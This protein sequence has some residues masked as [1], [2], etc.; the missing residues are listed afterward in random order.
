MSKPQQQPTAQTQSATPQATLPVALALTGAS[1]SIYGVRTLKRLT[2]FQIPVHLIIS[3]AGRIVLREETGLSARDLADNSLITLHGNNE[4]GAE[5]ASGSFPLQA[6][7]ICPC[8]ANTLGAIACGVG[9]NLIARLGAVA[10]KERWRLIIVPRESPYSTPLLEN[11][12][13]LSLYGAHIIPA[14]PSFYRQPESVTELVDTVVD[15]VLSKLDLP[16][17]LP[18]WLGPQKTSRRKADPLK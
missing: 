4:I 7:I 12:T 14:S 18:P 11:M 9:D 3:D 15:R 8:S 13:K 10:L 2:D 16:P 17:V 5:V 1:G 6:A